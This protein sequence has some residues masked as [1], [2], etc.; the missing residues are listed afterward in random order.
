MALVY[1]APDEARAQI[2]RAAA[3]QF[4]EGDVQHW[5]HPPAGRGVRTRISDDLLWLP[6]RGLPL[7][8]R[9]PAT[10]RCSTSGCRS[11]GR[12]CCTP[13]QEEDYGLPA[14]QRRDRRRS[15]STASARSSTGCKL[16]PHGLP[17]MGTGDWNDGMNQVGAGGKGESVWDGWFFVDRPE[18]V[19]DAG[20]GAR[21]HGAGGLVP[22]AGRGAARRARGSTPGTAAG[23]AAPTSTTARRSAR[24]TNDE[25]QIDS[26]AQ[27]WAVIS[28]AADP[29]AR[30]QAHGG[31]RTSAWS[32][33][34]TS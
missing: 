32:A 18:G 13:D 29:D 4:V 12:R 26:I 11:C 2:L 25:C 9:P 31:G 20:R 7:R 6:L 23:I 19:R 1:G 8:R 21:R 5:W 14:R 28:G 33:R 10:P 16:G 34:R 17:L 27:T 3:R 15:T 24:R 22:R 30:A